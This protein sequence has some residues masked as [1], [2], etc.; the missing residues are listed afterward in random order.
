[1]GP[2]IKLLLVLARKSILLHN[3]ANLW[4]RD[5]YNT[6]HKYMLDN[7]NYSELGCSIMSSALQVYY[8]AYRERARSLSPYRMR[9]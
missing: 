4:T 3:R 8:A 5:L 9:S 6:I 2:H 1:M 7:N